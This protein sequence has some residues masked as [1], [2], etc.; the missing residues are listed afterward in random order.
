M[1]A[2]LAVQILRENKFNEMD[3]I[4]SEDG[5]TIARGAIRT[6]PLPRPP[7]VLAAANVTGT[8]EVEFE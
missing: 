3:I 4:I 5:V 7:T 1:L 6:K 2:G 8:D